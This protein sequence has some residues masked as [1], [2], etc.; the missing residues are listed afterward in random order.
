MNPKL[1]SFAKVLIKV[2]FFKRWKSAKTDCNRFYYQNVF[3]FNRQEQGYLSRVLRNRKVLPIITWFHI[4]VLY[5]TFWAF[6]LHQIVVNAREVL[7]R[8]KRLKTTGL[9]S[10]KNLQD[11]FC[12]FSTKKYVYFYLSLNTFL[13]SF[14]HL[15]SYIF[16][17]W[18]THSDV[19]IWKKQQARRISSKKMFEPILKG[20]T[21]T[22]FQIYVISLDRLLKTGFKF[23]KVF[24]LIFND[25]K[26]DQHFFK[27][28]SIE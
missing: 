1:L 21:T 14:F 19:S 27:H 18:P 4:T 25:N 3:L 2:Y 17:A 7:W 22:V 26:F 16:S 23:E 8:E 28:P 15:Q 6:R 5:S 24:K 10:T 20:S 9:D 12:Y 11:G 13:L